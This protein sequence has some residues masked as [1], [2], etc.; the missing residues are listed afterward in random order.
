MKR[1]YSL[2][3]AMY[4]LAFIIQLVCGELFIDSSFWYVMN[5]LVMAVMLSLAIFYTRREIV[6]RML[7]RHWIGLMSQDT[8]SNS[9]HNRG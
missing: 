4:L 7:Y 9:R 6:N 1:D 2:A 8:E 3:I 5:L